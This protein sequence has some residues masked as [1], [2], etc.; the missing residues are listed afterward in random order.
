MDENKYCESNHHSY[1][2][3]TRLCSTSKTCPQ[4]YFI[5]HREGDSQPFYRCSKNCSKEEYIDETD[6]NKCV[7]SCGGK[8]YIENK[9]TKEKKC[10]STCN[11]TYVI[12]GKQCIEKDDC[13]YIK[14]DAPITSNCSTT[15]ASLNV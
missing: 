5:L 11:S 6:N 12:E 13:K 8:Y 15:C 14:D 7:T 3:D 2:L 1:D 9:Q 4:K 10:T